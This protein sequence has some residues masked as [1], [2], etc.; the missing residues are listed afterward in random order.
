MTNLT[1]TVLPVDHLETTL[2]RLDTGNGE[3]V[4]ACCACL[5]EVGITGH[6]PSRYL[7]QALEEIRAWRDRHSNS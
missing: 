1:A 2:R 5:Q 7:P 4:G 6:L 3:F